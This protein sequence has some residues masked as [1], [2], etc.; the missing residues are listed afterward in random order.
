MLG[1]LTLITKDSRLEIDNNKTE[2]DIKPI[3]LGEKEFPVCRT[4]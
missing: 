4:S 1:K 3:A 2:N